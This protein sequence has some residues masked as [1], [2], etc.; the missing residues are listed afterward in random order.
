MPVTSVDKTL[1][2]LHINPGAAG[3]QGWH[4]ERTLVRLTIEGNK[5][6]DCEVI[7]LSDINKTYRYENL[8]GNWCRRFHRFKLYQIPAYTRSTRTKTLRLSTR[9]FDVCR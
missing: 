3:M 9:L 2:L 4:K 6:T 5:F 1:N 7:T 8:L